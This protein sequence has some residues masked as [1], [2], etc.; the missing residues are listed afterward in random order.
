MLDLSA[1]HLRPPHDPWST[2][3]YAAYAAYAADV[4]DTV[5]DG[6]VLM[7]DWVLTTLD[8]ETVITDMEALV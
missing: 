2:L 4:R 7:R 8:E 5:V 3:A 6:R 1:P